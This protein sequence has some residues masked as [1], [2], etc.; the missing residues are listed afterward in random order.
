MYFLHL[1]FTHVMTKHVMLLWVGHVLL[2]LLLVVVVFLNYYY[3]YTITIIFIILRHHSIIN[4]IKIVAIF[5]K[6]LNIFKYHR[7]IIVYTV[8]SWYAVCTNEFTYVY[9]HV[10]L[11]LDIL[12]FSG[13]WLMGHSRFCYWIVKLIYWIYDHPRRDESQIGTLVDPLKYIH[14]GRGRRPSSS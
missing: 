1:I 11:L 10:S 14:K 9:I 6:R 5:L 13:L 8:T 7:P 2:L 4:M 12:P 3:Y